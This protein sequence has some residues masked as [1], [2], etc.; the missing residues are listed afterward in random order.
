MY[1]LHGQVFI[2]F[3]HSLFN[4]AFISARLNNHSC[5]TPLW[6]RTAKNPDE[7]TGP[8]ARLFAHSLALLTRLLALPCSLRS[9]ALLRSLIRVLAHFAHSLTRGTIVECTPSMIRTY[10]F[11]HLRIAL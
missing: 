11:A 2:P 8:L 10:F 3:P 7:N 9:H 4:T 1:F 5:F 6:S